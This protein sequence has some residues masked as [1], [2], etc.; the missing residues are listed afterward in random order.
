MIQYWRLLLWFVTRPAFHPLALG[1]G[2]LSL[3]GCAW[4]WSAAVRGAP[5]RRALLTTGGL[6]ALLWVASLLEIQGL[7]DAYVDT[8]AGRRPLRF[9]WFFLVQAQL[10]GAW[11]GIVSLVVLLGAA[12]HGLHRWGLSRMLRGPATLLG[13]GIVV[14]ATLIVRSPLLA[15]EPAAYFSDAERAELLLSMVSDA[16]ALHS[17]AQLAC[18]VTV[19]V[20]GLVWLALD[21]RV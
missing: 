17:T 20:T 11:L 10:L 21:W 8:L 14:A 5:L 13:A 12:A 18:W 19:G 2:V 16:S 6:V 7:R 4:L 9:P 1:L 15:E 3:A